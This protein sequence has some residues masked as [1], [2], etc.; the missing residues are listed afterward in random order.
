MALHVATLSLEAAVRNR[1]LDRG[2]G[3]VRELAVADALLLSRGA[4]KGDRLSAL[5]MQTR[6]GGFSRGV[7]RARAR[8]C[9]CFGPRA[10]RR[11]VGFWPGRS[12]RGKA[13]RF[14]QLSRSGWRSR[15]EGASERA[16]RVAILC[17]CVFGGFLFDLCR[18]VRSP[19]GLRAPRMS[20]A[21]VFSPRLSRFLASRA[22]CGLSPDEALGAVAA[23]RARLGFGAG[24]LA[25]GGEA[26]RED[27]AS[28]GGNVVER[29][30]VSGESA[31][32]MTPATAP[33]ESGAE[34]GEGHD[35]RC[36]RSGPDSEASGT[37]P[38]VLFRTPPPPTRSS[39]RDPPP[40]KAGSSPCCV[41]PGC[42]PPA[43]PVPPLPLPASAL[44]ALDRRSSRIATL[45]APLDAL[46]GGGLAP[47]ESL[48]LV[49]PPGSGKTQLALHSALNAQ[50]PPSLGGP[51]GVALFIDAEGA[52]VRSRLEE[53]AVAWVARVRAAAVAR[54]IRL[55]AWLRER[56]SGEEGAGRE[57]GCSS[58]TSALG[59][60]S[61]GL[62]PGCP[63]PT[64]S[65]RS[66]PF[67]ATPTSSCRSAPAPLTPVPTPRGPAAAP[68]A[69][70]RASARA[71]LRGLGVVRVSTLEEL[72]EA[73]HEAPVYLEQLQARVREERSRCEEGCGEG[74][75]GRKA[76]L[77][78]RDPHFPSTSATT[79]PSSRSC[80]PPSSTPPPLHLVVV[81][82]ALLLRAVPTPG[83]RADAAARLGAALARAVAGRSA[84][85]IVT[86]HATTKISG[87]RETEGRP[88]RGTWTP[89]AVG[90]DEAPDPD[91]D[92]A[93]TPPTSLRG[94]RCPGPGLR[95]EPSPHASQPSPLS[96]PSPGAVGAWR[97]APAGTGAPAAQPHAS[98]APA[99][100]SLGAWA[101]VCSARLVLTRLADGTRA[102]G[103]VRS[104]RRP[105]GA[106]R[107]ALT[108]GSVREWRPGLEA[109]VRRWDAHKA[110]E[111]GGKRELGWVGPD[112]ARTPVRA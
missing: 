68:S 38:A 101:H 20:L 112:A 1:L 75:L 42:P 8:R 83:A 89:T 103:L 66:A 81:D 91:P 99:L 4:Q 65:G 96:T 26:F 10:A 95:T 34:G 79:S 29:D 31:R 24:R 25:G 110:R 43:W 63:I 72:L 69:S 105:R 6:C 51:G 67:P 62:S 49:G 57:G 30:G 2:L 58:A 73:V 60:Q 86:M 37:G 106:C 39:F 70:L 61:S 27:D 17:D 82:G 48:E 76:A 41:P 50:L 92:P 104:N 14:K 13:G 36:L 85:A 54:K 32:R 84:A 88:G 12:T 23:A 90:R 98:L 45:C 3:D 80:P 108:Q 56:G 77:G 78:E 47:G 87:E 107:F 64:P 16:E 111:T 35:G 55:P 33:G 22:A 11:R 94:P 46:M 71:L 9:G 74:A 19:R 53:L 18:Q 28:G 44:L 21:A 109:Q 59:S 97:D 7:R 5:E 15:G 100:S 52:L 102:A 40:P 93:C